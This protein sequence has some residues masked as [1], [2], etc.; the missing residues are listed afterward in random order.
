MQNGYALASEDGLQKINQQLTAASENEIDQIRQL[1]QIGIQ[2]NTEVT[3][4]STK[5]LV[6]QA[7]CSALPVA[8]TN[9]PQELW[10]AFAKLVL[11]ATYEATFCTAI[12]NYIKTGN[13]KLFLTL[14]GGGVFRNETQWITDAIVRSVKLFEHV[15]L[16]VAI[17]SYSDSNESVQELIDSING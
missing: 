17:V 8:Y 1:L 6:S 7:Y 5:Q 4:S 16:D 13:N 3:I 12:L 15:D 10:S 9:L 2:W 11:E 14:I